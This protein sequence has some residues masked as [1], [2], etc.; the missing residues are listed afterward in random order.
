MRKSNPLWIL[1][2]TSIAILVVLNIVMS[3]STSE[4]REQV[5]S[6]QNKQPRNISF[7][8]K[9]ATN[10]KCPGAV[11]GSDKAFLR[12]KYFYSEYCPWCR[13]EEPILQKLLKNHGNVVRIE[14]YKNTVCPDLVAQYKVSGV[15]T[16]VFGTSTNRTEYTHHG[17]IYEKDLLKLV[18]D[19][20]G[21][22]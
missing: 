5:W 1:A 17:F 12:V 19:V 18:C 14:W 6:L 22:C 15:P 9:T 11:G 7:H 2:V 21:A 20:T 8:A 10:A 4:Y 16:F 3:I 13:K